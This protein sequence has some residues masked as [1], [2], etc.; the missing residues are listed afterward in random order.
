MKKKLITA[1]MVMCMGLSFAACGDQESTSVT[2]NQATTGNQSVEEKIDH[3]KSASEYPM[4]YEF[5]ESITPTYSTNTQD[6]SGSYYID[7]KLTLDKGLSE[8]NGVAYKVTSFI[9]DYSIAEQKEYDD[10]GVASKVYTDIDGSIYLVTGEGSV[11][12]EVDSSRNNEFENDW[13]VMYGGQYYLA[14]YYATVEELNNLGAYNYFFQNSNGSCN[15]SDVLNIEKGKSIDELRNLVE[16]WGQPSIVQYNYDSSAELVWCFDDVSV[17][18]WVMDLSQ[19][20]AEDR[21]DIDVMYVVITYCTY[22][23]MYD[24]MRT[25]SEKLYKDE[26]PV[27][28]KEEREV[29]GETARLEEA[30][31]LTSI[32]GKMPES[33]VLTYAGK[34]VDLFDTGYPDLNTM[35]TNVFDHPSTIISG[36]LYENLNEVNIAMTPKDTLFGSLHIEGE[37]GNLTKSLGCEFFK[38]MNALDVSIMGISRTSTFEDVFNIL[39]Y[40]EIDY[41]YRDT[42]VR[43][44]KVIGGQKCNISVYF[45]YDLYKDNFFVKKIYIDF[46]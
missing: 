27:K 2:N 12:L 20:K 32:S 33:I 5:M 18:I 45:E 3:E 38:A 19:Y 34:E 6:V 11:R 24:E 36:G 14:N 30:K 40:A 1:F 23:Q 31:K 46:D 22:E 44:E 37:N 9:E 13:N 8:L 10:W 7:E 15:I 26:A 29:A 42:S 21:K 41:T 17:R 25:E 28:E 39:G 4:L 43:Y 16:L 35:A